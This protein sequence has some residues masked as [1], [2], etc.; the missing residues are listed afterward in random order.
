MVELQE[1][2]VV[3]A[4]ICNRTL[5]DAAVAAITEGLR[6]Y[7]LFEISNAIIDLRRSGKF[8][9][10]LEIE[11]K[12]CPNVSSRQEASVLA[13]KLLGAV[14]Q[15][16]YV[17]TTRLNS[18]FYKTGSF[19]GDFRAELGDVAWEVIKLMGGWGP[20]CESCNSTDQGILRAQLRELIESVVA[21]AGAGN[22]DKAL[23]LPGKVN[24]PKELLGAIKEM[25][26]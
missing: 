14:S 18:D 7:Q 6:G 4:E 25:P 23:A 20:F 19:E 13:N 16:G 5:S 1:L 10:I 24:L 3:T 12:I 15:H 21:K 11:N 17:W 9:S 8:P 26:K 22:L 2:L